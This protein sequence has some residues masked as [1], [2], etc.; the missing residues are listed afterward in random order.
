ME[1]IVFEKI[2]AEKSL[3]KY[4]KGEFIFK[5]GTNTYGVYCLL[6]GK[7]KLVKRGEDGRDH[8]LRLYRTGDILGY[9]SFFGTSGY[10]ASAVA[11]EDCEVSF[12]DR[13]VFL[14]NLEDN[15]FLTFEMLKIFAKELKRTDIHLTNLAQKPV[16]ERAAEALL[17]IH[18]TYG[19]TEDGKT[20][21]ASFSREEIATIVGT[22]TESIIRVLSDFNK[23]GLIELN[24]KEIAIP[25]IAK[26]EKV[27]TL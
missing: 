19:F 4:H 15:Y 6:K 2:N 5:E 20:L 18:Q 25:N 13:E 9:R 3:L 21:N 23:D 10:N 14:Q 16:R 8:I 1:H 24:G 7:V 11:I 26:L 27:A 17:F 12:I 22:A